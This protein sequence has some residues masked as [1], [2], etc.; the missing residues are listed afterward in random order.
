MPSELSLDRIFPG[1]V[2]PSQLQPGRQLTPSEK[3]WA[4]VVVE[5]ARDAG[6]P[7]KRVREEARAWA[8]SETFAWQCAA[9]GLDEQS[10]RRV[11]DQRIAEAERGTAPAIAAS[12]VRD[13]Y[14]VGSG[15]RKV[16]N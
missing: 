12:A 3:L 13:R 1:I 15:R 9:L 6:S 2:L 11:I 14:S 10:V 4:A 16:G 5:G 7:A 8:R